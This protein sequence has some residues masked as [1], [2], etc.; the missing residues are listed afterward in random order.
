MTE[1]QLTGGLEGVEGPN[2]IGGNKTNQ[3][4]S[5]KKNLFN[6]IRDT[7]NILVLWKP[8]NLLIGEVAQT[9]NKGQFFEKNKSDSFHKTLI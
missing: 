4:F 6:L 5:E 9:N 7:H 1:P 8:S 3:I 2:S